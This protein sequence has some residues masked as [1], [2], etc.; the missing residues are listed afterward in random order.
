MASPAISQALGASVDVIFLKQFF[1][2][3][4]LIRGRFPFHVEDFFPGPEVSFRLP[5]TTQTPF[6]QERVLPPSQGHLIDRPVTGRAADSLVHM[7]VVLEIGEVGK[8]IDADPLNGFITSKTLADRLQYRILGEYLRVTTHASFGRGDPGEG[9]VFDAGMTVA[10]I[11][12]VVA[13]MV[14]VAEWHRLI[15]HDA[16]FG[17]PG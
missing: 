12:P 9:R 17:H 10:A 8:I 16:R 2:F 14:F 4:N 13:Y 11:D 7:D 3:L 6:H 5:M 1:A 15:A